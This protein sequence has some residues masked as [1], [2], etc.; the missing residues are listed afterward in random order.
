MRLTVPAVLAL[1]SLCVAAAP[2]CEHCVD[3]WQG[4]VDAKA[5]VAY[6]A[7]VKAG[8]QYDVRLSPEDANADLIVAADAQYPPEMVLCRSARGAKAIDSCRF[9]ARADMPVH[10][11]VVG[12][13][14]H[15][16]FQLTLS[17][18]TK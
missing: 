10:V 3:Q 7:L 8:Q 17:Q 11:Y 18:A 5:R 14:H 15:T 6:M 16:H 13:Y 9:S 12:R 1:A 2:P 4:S